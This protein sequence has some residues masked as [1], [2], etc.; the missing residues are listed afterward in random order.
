MRADYID[1]LARGRYDAAFPDP[2]EE[3]RY[4]QFLVHARQ[5]GAP[6]VLV[7][8][9][10]GHDGPDGRPWKMWLHLLL[11]DDHLTV[12]SL[13]AR[14]EAEPDRTELPDL[15]LACLPTFDYVWPEGV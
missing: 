12:D 2:V 10:M 13:L 15:A 9:D 3:R 1:H 6:A 8:F 14:D 4:A 7:A 5:T 11:R